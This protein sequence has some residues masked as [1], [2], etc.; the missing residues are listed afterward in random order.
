[1]DQEVSGS[2]PDPGT[3]IL[4]NLRLIARTPLS[5]RVNQEST[6]ERRSCG[7]NPANFPS[8]QHR[9]MFA[10]TGVTTSSHHAPHHASTPLAR[11][12]CTARKIQ[13]GVGRETVRTSGECVHLIS[14]RSVRRTVKSLAFAPQLP[15]WFL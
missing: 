14:R 10:E 3:L 6:T 8:L 5:L 1:M 7:P 11:S 13:L 9:R 4:L 12:S 2:I 15:H